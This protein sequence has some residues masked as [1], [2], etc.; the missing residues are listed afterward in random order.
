MSGVRVGE[1]SLG[2]WDYGLGVWRLGCFDFVFMSK[3]WDEW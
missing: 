1:Y 2:G 3:V